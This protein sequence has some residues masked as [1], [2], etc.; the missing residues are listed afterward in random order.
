M[1]HITDSPHPPGTI[2]LA[3]G[4][5][6][7]FYEFQMSLDALQAPTGTKLSVQR[8]CDIT[9]NFNNGLKTM[10]GEWAWFLADDHTFA[11]EILMH[12]LD[13]QVDVVV[14]IT[15]CKVLP[16]MPCVMHGPDPGEAIWHEDM[17]LYDWDEL[18]GEGIMALPK[19]EFI[20]QA[21][22]LVRKPVLDKIGYPW[23]KC[24]QLDPGRLQEDMKFCHDIQSLGYTIWVDQDII[25][26]HYFIIGV[27]ARRHNGK[28]VPAL[29][30]GKNVMVL[31]DAKPK[32][33]RTPSNKENIKALW[34]RLPDK[35]AYERVIKDAG[36]ET[37]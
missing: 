31:P 9:S 33:N 4:V 15:P 26:D 7:R 16:W 18:S 19:G 10:T 13:K 35:E 23:F 3:A 17:L 5:Q 25:F 29:V 30:S 1:I 22:M 36:G 28:W 2:I 11:P 27:S 20:G 34:A 6:P 32:W 8:S 37:A 14:P 21:G 12:L 24:G